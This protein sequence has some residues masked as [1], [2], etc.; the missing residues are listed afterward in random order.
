MIP[1]A[2]QHDMAKR[3]GAAVSESKASHAVYVSQPA[4]VV[5]IIVEAASEA[6]NR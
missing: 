3:A 2:A 5:K 6:N 4:A 1:P